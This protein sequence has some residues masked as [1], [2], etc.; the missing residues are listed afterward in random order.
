MLDTSGGE[1]LERWGNYILVRPDPQVIWNTPRR[2]R[3]GSTTTPAMSAPIP[4]ADNGRSISS[5][6]AG[7]F[8]TDPDLQRQAHEFQ[9]HRRFPGAG[10]QLGFHPGEDGGGSAGRPV[11]V[12]NL[13]AYTGGATLAGGCRRE[14]RSAMWMPPRAWWPGP[15]KT[16]RPPAWRTR[17]SAGLWTTAP[18]SSSG[19][20]AGDGATTPSSWTRP[21]MAGA[22][23]ARSGSW[24]TSLYPFVELVTGVL[25]DDPLFVIINSYTTGLAPSVPGYMPGHGVWTGGMAAQRLP[26]SWACR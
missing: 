2:I 18:S 9:A 26:V 11:Q 21:P 20:S 12:L 10:G 17:P 19:R 14:Q 7:R 4:A 5:R 8:N 23:R 3:A 16:P 22:R 13:F 24:R 25:S 6:N 15:R 1:K